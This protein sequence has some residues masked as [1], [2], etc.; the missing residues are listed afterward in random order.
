MQLP[1]VAPGGTFPSRE[2]TGR[3]TPVDRVSMPGLDQIQSV[4]RA[5]KA[6]LLRRYPVRTLGVFGSCARREAGPA[7]DIDILVDVRASMG[8]LQFLE[9]QEDL[10]RLLGARVDLV[11]RDALKPAIGERILREVVPI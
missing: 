6:E 2:K 5:H 4:L 9:L 7:S 1:K 10:E 8:L 3:I 11:A